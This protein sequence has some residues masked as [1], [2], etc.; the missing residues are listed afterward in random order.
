MLASMI[1]LAAL[2]AVQ[3]GDDWQVVASKDGKFHVELPDVP[4][5]SS[6][7]QVPGPFGP[8]TINETIR[9][10]GGVIYLIDKISLPGPLGRGDADRWIAFAR[11]RATGWFGAGQPQVSG[12]GTT[13][14]GVTN[15]TFS[16]QVRRRGVAAHHLQGRVAIQGDTLFLLV[17]FSANPGKPVP[18]GGNRFLQSFGF[19]PPPQGAAVA[20]KPGPGR[21]G[22]GRAGRR[23]ATEDRKAV[24]A[25]PTNPT[26]HQGGSSSEDDGSRDYS[27][28]AQFGESNGSGYTLATVESKPA[29]TG[30]P[31][32]ARLLAY[33]RD[34]A[35]QQF[36]LEPKVVEERPIWLG[37]APGID[38]ELTVDRF[39][40]GGRVQARGRAFSR[41]NKVYVAVIT[42]LDRARPAPTAA[43]EQFLES[44]AF[45]DRP[46]D[47]ISLGAPTAGLA[48]APAA[49]GIPHAPGGLAGPGVGGGPGSMGGP[50]LPVAAM[51]GRAGFGLIVLFTPRPAALRLLDVARL[52][53]SASPTPRP[54]TVATAP[55]AGPSPGP[56]GL[57]PTPI[58]APTPAMAATRAAD[59]SPAAVAGRAAVA[60]AAATKVAD[61]MAAWGRVVD[62]DGD[63]TFRPSGTTLAVKLPGSAHVLAPER[64]KM[65]APRVVAPARG[66][67]E[68]TVR[69]AGAFRPVKGSTVKGLSSREAGGLILWKDAAN[70]LVVQH[71]ASIGDD[72]EVE[73]Q[74]VLEELVGGREG[75]HDPPGRGRRADHPPP[76]AR[77]RPGHGVLPGRGQGLEAAQAGRDEL[78]GRLAR[79]G[80]GRRQHQP[81]AAH[82]HLR[83]LRRPAQVTTPPAGWTAGRPVLQ[84]QPLDGCRTTIPLPPEARPR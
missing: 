76:G 60:R 22:A 84:W 73:H 70:Y 48:H 41:D 20:A 37:Q 12:R 1:L 45:A 17:A 26:G 27:Y 66:D 24:V 43:A 49:P 9:Q 8:V 14:N 53:M 50:G 33:A 42:T 5:Q 30:T 81:R 64:G 38:F 59:S 58:V 6:T 39:G 63:V 36:G 32:E 16:G 4:D 71:R 61:P 57:A 65:N 52:G 35:A 47:K 74:V 11:D 18:P 75:G 72:G 7:V 40:G 44:F 10:P 82:A 25:M 51:A 31:A 68:A 46:D 62:P 54:G 55:P 19:G 2:A 56:I 13:T 83:R 29:F 21:G 80:R 79:G 3:N 78:G 28:D 15:F 77:G 34:K 69:V 23:V 67:F